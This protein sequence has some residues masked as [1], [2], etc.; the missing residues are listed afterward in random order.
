MSEQHKKE[1]HKPEHAHHSKAKSGFKVKKIAMWQGATV[2]LALLLIFLV[3]TRPGVA[4]TVSENEAGSKTMEFINDIIL[5]GARTASFKGVET[6]S[7]LY[8]V[9]FEVEGQ[10]YPAYVSTDGKLLFLQAIDIDAATAATPAQSQQ[11]EAP[12]DVPKSEKRKVEVFVM[13]HCP[14]GTMIEKGI[15]PVVKLMGSKIDF[16]VKFV[17]YAMHG[18]TEID[19]QL[20]QHCIQKEAEGKY[21]EY[22]ECFLEDGDTE[23]CI[24]ET[25]FTEGQFDSCIEATDKEFKIS[26]LYDDQSTWLSG[27]YPQFNVNADLNDKY[28]VRG[29]PHLVINEATVSSGR[30]PASLL[31]AVCAAFETAPAEC[32]TELSSAQPSAGFGFAEN[33]APASAGTCG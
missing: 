26:E 31:S 30:A 6:Q 17:D 8:K 32:S 12:P 11:D 24:G 10:N 22:L 20:L 7:N 25:G 27:K 18:Q 4:D 28:G 16:S 15:L 13:T 2:I 9:S 1:I 23:R 3:A 5:E 14:F 19:E 29:S 21:L 33:S